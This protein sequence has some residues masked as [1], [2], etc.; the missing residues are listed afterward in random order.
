MTDNLRKAARDLR[1]NTE[2]I[3]RL[4]ARMADA[5]EQLHAIET[6][7][8]AAKTAQEGFLYSM[9]EAAM[10][11]EEGPDPSGESGIVSKH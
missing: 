3:E 1:K 4:E 11:V 9:K 8:A 2:K 5:W 7:L 10:G 6:D